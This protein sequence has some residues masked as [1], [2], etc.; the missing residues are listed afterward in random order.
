MCRFGIKQKLVSIVIASFCLFG[1]NLSALTLQET[2]V[3]VINTNP[4]VQEKLKTFNETQQDL[5]IAKSEWLPS[6]DYRGTFGRNSG[7][8]LKDTARDSSYNSYTNS[9][10]ITQNLFN[11]FS[12][13][14]KINYQEAKVLGAAYHYLESANEV[15]YQMVGAYIDLLRSY[16]L[17]QN[18]KENVDINNKIYQDV[19]A[20]YRRG[21]TTKS[22]MTKI[23]ASLSLAN[24]NYIVQ[25]TNNMDKEFRFKRLF[26][27][28]VNVGTLEVP[29]LNLAMPES[30]QR[31]TMIAISN[32]PSMIVSDYNIKSAQAI[33]KEKK[34]K[35]YPRLDVEAEQLFNDSSPINNGYENPDDRKRI[36]AV[37]NWNLYKGGADIADLQRSKSTIYKEVEAQRNLKRQTIESLELSWSAYEMIGKQLQDLYKYYEYSEETS[38]SYKREY[39]LGRRTLLDL[40]SAQNDLI[41]SKAQIINAQMDKLFAQYRILDAMGML[42]S[43]VLDEQDYA[44]IV[45]VTTK[46]FDIVEDELPINLDVDKDGIVDRLDIC[47]NS[48]V[49]NDD[50]TPYGCNQDKKDSDF[51]GIPDD[52][53][54]CPNTPFGA[55][56][57][58]T[59]CPVGGNKF[60]MTNGEYISN[61]LAYNEESPQKAE[62]LGVYDY[63][64]DV[65]ASKNVAS[66]NLDKHLM[67]DDFEIIKRFDAINIDNLGESKLIEKLDALDKL[68]EIAEVLKEYNDTNAV[69]TIIGNTERTEDKNDSFNRG[70]EYANSVKAS[71][72]NRGIDEKIL[73]A[74]S[75]V[76]YDNTF[77]ETSW[78]DGSLNKN[79]YISLYVPKNKDTKTE[80]VAKPEPVAIV[81]VVQEDIQFKEGEVIN[82]DVQ[83]SNDKPKSISKGKT[84]EFKQ[85]SFRIEPNEKIAELAKFLKD[86][87]EYNVKIVGHSSHT[88]D[89]KIRT[90]KQSAEYNI[91]LSLKRANSVKEILVKDG[92]DASRVITEGKGFAEPIASNATKEGQNKNRRVEA[93]LIKR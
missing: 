31:A 91:E 3:E 2:L 13:I 58:E 47:D 64:F 79:V 17:L 20:L 92:V 67:Y 38:A 75:R 14:Q 50:I 77:L 89:G 59:G 62:E 69:V 61:V 11:G 8:G 36:Y 22:E 72:I 70:L 9:L 43:S 88:K 40:L 29:S 86:H 33:Y 90:K 65:D 28:S 42:V 66:N 5:E 49:G 78:K 6:I 83:M 82:L 84:A 68:N 19:S 93:T 87:Q 51:D 34:S 27:R 54:Q 37:M 46:P 25:Q 39:E 85:D 24:S 81:N 71:L 10:K 1:M 55:I 53:D 18:A 57:D 74:Q 35:F 41:N 23:H 44:N 4:S 12:T 30:I 21:L 56:V 26:G 52:I 73:V 60:N 32:N 76:D 16:Q 63:E 15:S 45:K 48:I 7:G 80:E